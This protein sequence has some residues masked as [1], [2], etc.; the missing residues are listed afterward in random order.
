MCRQEFAASAL[1]LLARIVPRAINARPPF[2]ALSRSGFDELAAVRT[3]VPFAL[4]R[5]HC[6]IERVVEFRSNVPSYV[7]QIEVVVIPRLLGGRAFGI[8]RHDAGRE[9]VPQAVHHLPCMSTVRLPPP[10]FPGGITFEP[11]PIRLGSNR[12]ESQLRRRTGAV[13]ARP[14]SVPLLESCHPL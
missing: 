14:T 11:V 13:L 12:S 1:D 4:V 6:L 9:N 5:R 8:A 7:P 3:G 2:S 10:V